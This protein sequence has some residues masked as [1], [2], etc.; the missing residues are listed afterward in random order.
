MPLGQTTTLCFYTSLVKAVR[1]IQATFLWL[2]L[3]KNVMFKACNKLSIDWAPN[4]ATGIGRVINSQ[5]LIGTY[6]KRENRD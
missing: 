6:N 3:S 4:E 1:R 5:V 2:L